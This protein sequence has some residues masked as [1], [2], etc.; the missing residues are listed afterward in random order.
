MV[1]HKH[2]TQGIRDPGGNVGRIPEN[3]NHQQ[4]GIVLRLDLASRLQFLQR[5]REVQTPPGLFQIRI[6]QD[7]IGLGLNS[8][9]RIIAAPV[10]I[11]TIQKY[12]LRLIQVASEDERQQQSHHCGSQGK[13]DNEPPPPDD[14]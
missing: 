8:E 7:Y 12:A 4:S 13:R 6:Q 1:G 2:V 9:R 3:L 5:Y 10:Q 14:A 11:G